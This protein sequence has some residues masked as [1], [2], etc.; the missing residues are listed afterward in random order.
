MKFKPGD[1]VQ[2]KTWKEMKKE[3]GLDQDGDIMP[4]GSGIGFLRSMRFLCGAYATVECVQNNGIVKLKDIS[5]ENKQKWKWNFDFTAYMLKPANTDKYE[6]HIMSDGKKTTAVYKKNGDVVSRSEANLHPDDDFNFK[7][8]A[9]LAFDRVFPLKAEKKENVL[10]LFDDC[11]NCYGIVGTPTKYKDVYGRPLFVGD[12][13][14]I[15][16]AFISLQFV[17]EDDIDGAYILGI[18]KACDPKTGTV[19]DWKIKLVTPFTEVKDGTE[20]SSITCRLK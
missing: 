17:G 11:G 6:L 18:Q 15:E 3:Y 19:R 9:Q 10:R 16:N 4:K 14:E 20:A 8:G 7:T 13:V 5:P 1:R 2:F 12:V